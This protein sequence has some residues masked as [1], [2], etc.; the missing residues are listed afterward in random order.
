MEAFFGGQL[1][2]FVFAILVGIIF[3]Y[4]GLP[5]LIGQVVT[6]LFVGATGL[7]NTY[8]LDLF[9]NLSSFGIAML[10]FLVGLEMNLS[11]LKKIGGLA[12]KFFLIQTTGIL[13]LFYGLLVLVFKMEGSAAWLMALALSFSSTIVVVKVLSEKKNLNSLAGKVGVAVLLLQDIV[14]MLMLS[15]IP[16][17]KTGDMLESSL[18]VVKLLLLMVL[19]NVF[20]QVIVSRILGKIVK[21]GEDLVLVSLS[22]CLIVAMLSVGVFGLSLEIGCFLAGVS[23]SRSW[24]HFQ[25]LHKIKT[26]R[27]IFVSVFFIVLGVEAGMEKVNWEMVTGLT[28]IVVFG[29][30]LVSYVASVLAGLSKRVGVMLSLSLTQV[31]EFSLILAALG[32]SSGVWDNELVGAVII[33]GLL[34]MTISTV[35][36]NKTENII[37]F[38]KKH[39]MAVLK[40]KISGLHLETKTNHII[41]VGIDR[42]GRGIEKYLSKKKLN[43]LLVDFNPDIVKQLAG[44]GRSVI[45]A[46][47]CDPD[48]LDQMN[49]AEARL[50]ISTVKDH[51]DNMSFLLEIKRRGIKTPVIV[52]AENMDQA[53]ELYKAGASYVIFPHF[54]SGWHLRQLVGKLVRD[55]KMLARYRERQIEALSE[56]YEVAS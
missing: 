16:N 21:T 33:T 51:E 9:K 28:L 35:L 52:D 1:I 44:Q 54:V 29:K 14:A 8:D 26:L 11:E 40:E 46:D 23:L 47:I 7:M 6:G 50:I 17:I 27:D 43:Y 12:L 3:R 4:F 36:M 49:A 53:Q 38:I 42:T 5:S 56:I 20:G 39:W 10:L 34:S 31:S 24:S 45:F 2:V 41:L 30:L 32:L 18:V 19:V 15:L 25:I 48:S 55:K 22:W 37:T 13:L